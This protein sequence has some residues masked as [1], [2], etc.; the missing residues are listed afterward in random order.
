[1]SATYKVRIPVV[2]LACAGG[3][4]MALE[5]RLARVRGASGV[6]VNP[7]TEVVYAEVESEEVEQ[8]IRRGVEEAGYAAP[9]RVVT[10]RSGRSAVAPTRQRS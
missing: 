4:A 2:G 10:S 1:M 9:G 8:E 7:A 6:F 5:R 3:D